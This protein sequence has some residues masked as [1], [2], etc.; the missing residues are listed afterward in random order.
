MLDDEIRY[1]I[2]VKNKKITKESVNVGLNNV[3]LNTIILLLES[4][5]KYEYNYTNGVL[6]PIGP[7]QGDSISEAGGANDNYI[8]NVL[9]KIDLKSG[10]YYLVISNPIQFQTSLY[11]FHKKSLSDEN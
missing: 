11:S 7:A 6:T 1:K 10:E 2:T 9:E 8:C 5:H 3:D 4:P